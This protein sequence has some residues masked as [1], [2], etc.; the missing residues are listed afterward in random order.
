[1]IAGGRILQPVFYALAAEQ[2][3]SAPPA[4]KSDAQTDEGQ[5]TGIRVVEGRLHYCTQR[6]EYQDRTVPLNADARRSAQAVIDE[7]RT[8]SATWLKVK[9]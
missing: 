3:L 6:G 4:Q 9:P 2:L 5:A 8:A 7:V 1:M